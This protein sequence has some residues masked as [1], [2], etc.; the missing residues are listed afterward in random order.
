MKRK[1]SLNLVLASI[2]VAIALITAAAFWFYHSPYGPT[3]P[4]IRTGSSQSITHPTDHPRK[5][6]NLRATKSARPCVMT[7]P[8]P[9]SNIRWVTYR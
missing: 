5:S 6:S 3:I 2:A 1:T 8:I 7:L 9:N 4:L